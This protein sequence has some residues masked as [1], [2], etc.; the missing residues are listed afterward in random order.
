MF[1]VGK[2][3]ERRNLYFFPTIIDIKNHVLLAISAIEKGELE[4]V[5]PVTVSHL[6]RVKKL[7]INVHRFTLNLHGLKIMIVESFPKNLLAKV[8]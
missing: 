8:R 5:V 1:A 3:P 4:A 6:I 2:V 7:V